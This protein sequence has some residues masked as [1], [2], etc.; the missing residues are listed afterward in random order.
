[1]GRKR[2]ERS[3]ARLLAVQTLYMSQITGTGVSEVIEAGEPLP[4][5]AVL[6]PYAET[7]L[8]GVDE[9]AAELDGLLADA[10]ENWSVGRMPPVDY[11]I[12]RIALYEMLYEQA[13]PVS[14]CINEAV[15]LAKGMGGEDD[16]ARFVNGILGQIARTHLPTRAAQ[17]PADA[18]GDGLDAA[19]CEDDPGAQAKEETDDH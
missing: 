11:A 4:D 13:V 19:A 1:M 8:A 12:M 9:H 16:S 7:L 5:G 14:V 3:Q 15:E 18:A 2:H 17:E 6:S 10:S